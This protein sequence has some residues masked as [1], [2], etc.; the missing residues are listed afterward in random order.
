MKR[1]Q[2]N[3]V[4]IILLGIVIGLIIT[5]SD[6]TKIETGENKAEIEQKSDPIGHLR[7]QLRL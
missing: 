5:L 3:K 7:H 2:R 6:L 4:L 1:T